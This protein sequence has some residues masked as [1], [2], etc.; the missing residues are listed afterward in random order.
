[1]ADPARVAP[2]VGI[3]V[4]REGFEAAKAQAYALGYV[5]KMDAA[6]FPSIKRRPNWGKA[7]APPPPS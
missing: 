1:M 3:T 6:G 5:L 2:L 4:T 7:G